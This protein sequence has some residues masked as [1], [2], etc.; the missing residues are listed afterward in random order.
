MT[1]KQKSIEVLDQE[2]RGALDRLADK[3]EELAREHKATELAAGRQRERE[4]ERRRG[5]AEE[6]ERRAEEEAKSRREKIA[7]EMGELDAEREGLARR[8]VEILERYQE[9]NWEMIQEVSRY[10]TERANAMAVRHSNA[11]YAWVEDRLSRW[12]LR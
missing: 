10:D 12:L 4:E 2:A 11:P 3:R 9:L 5:E 7:E 8:L 6:A 1:T